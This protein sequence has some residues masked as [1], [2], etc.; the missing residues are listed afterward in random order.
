MFAS[1]WLT[2]RGR[3]ELG[4]A[5]GYGAYFFLGEGAE[6][7]LRLQIHRRRFCL[8]SVL[9]RFADQQGFHSVLLGE[10][11]QWNKTIINIGNFFT[12][13]KGVLHAL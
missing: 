7:V 11:K 12:I 1:E 6:M 9:W 5:L 3:Q 8:S 10:C 13:G 2:R 4:L